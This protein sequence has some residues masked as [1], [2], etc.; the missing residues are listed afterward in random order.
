MVRRPPRSTRPDPLFPYTT[1]F[2][3]RRP[4]VPDHGRTGAD[5]MGQ[6]QPRIPS[7]VHLPLHPRW[8]RRTT[9]LVQRD[10]PPADHSRNRRE[11]ADRPRGDGLL[12]LT[13]PGVAADT[14]SDYLR[15]TRGDDDG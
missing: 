14:G 12:L 2:R 5:G 15:P 1:L 8:K 3:S 10:G 6:H 11:A 7:T 13:A 4:P 9:R